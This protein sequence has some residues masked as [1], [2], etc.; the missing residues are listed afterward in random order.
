MYLHPTRTTSSMVEP[1]V[2]HRIAAEPE[3]DITV[4]IVVIAVFSG[5]L[6]SVIAAADALALSLALVPLIA[7]VALSAIPAE[8]CRR[9]RCVLVVVVVVA[10]T[11]VLAHA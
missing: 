1:R 7:A 9:H 10:A 8:L 4:V 6:N 5:R 3:V 2:G 11:P